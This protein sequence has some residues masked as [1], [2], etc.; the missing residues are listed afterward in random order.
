MLGVA[1]AAPNTLA[2]IQQ[3]GEVVIA[4]TGTQEPFSIFIQDG[5]IMGMDIDLGQFIVKAMCVKPKFEIFPF[6]KLEEAVLS[7]KADMAISGL[8]ITRAREA[9]VDM[10]GPYHVTGSSVLAKL[11]NAQLRAIAD[12]K[13]LQSFDSKDLT[14][15]ALKGSTSEV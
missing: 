14:L 11:S 5:R 3:K 12:T 7:G 9:K 13:D 6:D 8:M 10:V 15:A 1:T 4:T 2:A